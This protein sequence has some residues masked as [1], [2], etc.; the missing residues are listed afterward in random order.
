M[1][2]YVKSCAGYC[3]MTY[4][5][6]VGDRH[7]DNLMLT[8][9][10]NLFHIDFGFMLSAA[11]SPGGGMNFEKAPFKLTLEFIE[12]MGGPD[13]DMFQY[14]RT[15]VRQGF[16]ASRK[17]MGEILPLLEIIL[18]ESK[19]PCL[20]GGKE[21]VKA[22]EDR[23]CLTMTEEALTAHVE[24]LVEGSLSSLRTQLYDQFQYLSNGI[25]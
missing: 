9:E 14:F 21:A 16:V 23:F 7:F 24:Q 12:V 20:V 13:G 22:F 19:L 18:P 3:V 6:G 5:L 4:L 25:R 17:H 2:T 10:G 15:L 11:N 1:D 8:E